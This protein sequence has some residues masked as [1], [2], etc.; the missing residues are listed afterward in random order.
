VELRAF[1]GGLILC[2]SGECIAF[3]IGYKKHIL[4]SGAKGCD[5]G[6]LLYEGDSY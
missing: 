3:S 6:I 1:S 4:D 2:F 5:F